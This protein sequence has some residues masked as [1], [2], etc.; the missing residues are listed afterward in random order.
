MVTPIK[1]QTLEE[2]KAELNKKQYVAPQTKKFFT[3]TAPNVIRTA[4]PQFKGSGIQQTSQLKLSPKPMVTAQQNALQQMFGGG[5]HIWGSGTQ[6]Y[7]NEG[8]LRRGVGLTNMDVRRETK[9][10]FIP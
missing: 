2:F 10:L 1:E 6:I 5:Q 9:R 4:V 7:S 8:H 3:K